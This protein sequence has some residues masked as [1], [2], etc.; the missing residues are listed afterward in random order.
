LHYELTEGQRINSQLEAHIRDLE[1]HDILSAAAELC[2]D[3]AVEADAFLG[4]LHGQI[5]VHSVALLPSIG[6]DHE[7]NLAAVIDFVKEPETANPISP[8]FRLIPFEFFDVS[9]EKRLCTELGIDVIKQAGN[10][11]FPLGSKVRS[12]V[13]LELLGLEYPVVTQ[14]SAPGPS[15]PGDARF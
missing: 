10:H 6:G 11:L 8:C 1:D 12:K 9:T 15:W 2:A 5:P 14:R 7:D 13:G 3:Q 4:G